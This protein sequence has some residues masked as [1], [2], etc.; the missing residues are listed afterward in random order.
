METPKRTFDIL[1]IALNN[2][3]LQNA[4]NAKVKGKWEGISTQEF[5]DRVQIISSGLL[6]LGVQLGDKVATIT[7][8]RPEWNIIN[9]AAEQIGEII[10]PIYPTISNDDY[11][12]IFN[13]AIFCLFISI[14]LMCESLY[15]QRI[16]RLSRFALYLLFFQS[17]SIPLVRVK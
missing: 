2:H 10:C 5:Y 17:P 12:Y 3:P 8:N 14:S 4:L 1:E 6:E 13:D 11:T 9:Y 7:N 16:E 15:Y